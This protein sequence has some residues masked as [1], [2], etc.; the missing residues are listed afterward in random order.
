M[1]PVFIPLHLLRQ[2]MASLPKTEGIAV[3]SVFP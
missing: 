3:F 2:L 1:Y